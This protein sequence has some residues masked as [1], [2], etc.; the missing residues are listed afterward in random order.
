MKNLAAVV[1]FAV[2]MMFAPVSLLEARDVEGI[3]AIVNDEVIS[4]YDVDQRVDLFFATSGL[5]KSPEMR[6]RMRA[7]VLRSLVDEK[8]QMQENLKAQELIHI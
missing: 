1:S 4:L 7:Q 5:G 6:E 2:A 3:A 8:L